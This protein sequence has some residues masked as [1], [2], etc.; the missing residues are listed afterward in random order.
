[1]IVSQLQIYNFRRFKSMDGKPGLSITFMDFSLL[2]RLEFFVFRK[3][4]SE[5]TMNHPLLT[6][7]HLCG[8]MKGFVLL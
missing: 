1:M 6:G 3:M 8:N 7:G 4:E 2:I 5:S